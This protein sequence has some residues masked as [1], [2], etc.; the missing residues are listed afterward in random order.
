[1][2][3]VITDVF[4]GQIYNAVTCS[5][6]GH[7]HIS[8]D[9]F[10]S[11]SLNLPKSSTAMTH[12]AQLA[13]CFEDFVKEE[14][15]TSDE[16]FRCARCR[17]AVPICKRSVLWRLP[18][19]LI[20][21]LKRFHC[22]TWRKEKLDTLIEFDLGNFALKPYCGESSMMRIV[23]ANIDHG[24]AKNPVYAL[25]GV[26]NHVGSLYYGHYT[27]YRTQIIVGIGIAITCST[28]TGTTSTTRT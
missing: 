17:R 19:V 2:N 4:Q 18:P 13:R 7:K 3:S 12:R 14:R 6:C 11:L 23:T 5:D 20:V 21:H 8:F 9:T 25:Y 1:M 26:I 16:G 28:G 10:L 27:A 22:S 24:S 15:I